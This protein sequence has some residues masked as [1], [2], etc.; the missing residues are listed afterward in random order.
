MVCLPVFN[1]SQWDLIIIGWRVKGTNLYTTTPPVSS[2]DMWPVWLGKDYI[3]LDFLTTASTTV[4][5]TST[6]IHLTWYL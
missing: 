5:N 4:Q 1:F 3:N 2:R 6:T